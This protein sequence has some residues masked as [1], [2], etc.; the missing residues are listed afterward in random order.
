M[1]LLLNT[2]GKHTMLNT[3]Q[4][5]AL[6]RHFFTDRSYG[7]SLQRYILSKNPKNSADIELIERQWQYRQN[8][9]G[10]QWL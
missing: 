5:A 7:D 8:N 9:H 3:D 2:E 10:G 1:S 6:F 4:I